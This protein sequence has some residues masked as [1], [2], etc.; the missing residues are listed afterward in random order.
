MKSK[1]RPSK[2]PEEWEVIPDTHEGIVMQEEF[3][4]VQQLITS[5]R[6]PENKGGFENIFA[7][8]IKCADCGY[9]LQAMSAN[10]RKRPDIIDC[11]QYT[12]N[13]YGRYGNVMCTAHAI[14]ARDLFNAVFADINRFVVVNDER[15]V[16]AIENRL[17][18]TDQSK[19]KALE[20]EQRKL[21]KR[22]AELD[23]LFSSLYEDKVM[24]RIT[25]RNFEMMSGKYQKEQLEIEARLKEVTETLTESYEK[26][27]GARDFLSL[28]RNY[29]GITE[30]EATIINAL[31]DKILVSEREKLADGTVRQ[32]IKIY[33]KFI[34]FVG[35]LHITSTKR[36]TA[37]KSKNCT[38]CGV[39]Y[40]LGSGI[41]KY[42]HACAK[43]IQ[44]EKS[45]AGAGNEKG[46]LLN[47]KK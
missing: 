37:L 19:A 2:L 1:K 31:I 15:A 14:E 24:E 33:Y 18:E 35:E 34:G 6:L 22:L 32:E 3:D 46:W 20:K 27:Q 9:A 16:R 5:R 28:I 25:E 43:K 38:V 12:C 47:C 44:R 41:S 7:G 26:S 29:Q 11:V 42:C 36:W 39:E 30:L 17:T 8:V 4:T 10:R 40:I 13:N 23:R 21:S 45:N